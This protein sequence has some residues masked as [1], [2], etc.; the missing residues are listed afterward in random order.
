MRGKNTTEKLDDSQYNY[1]Q[2]YDLLHEIIA[3]NRNCD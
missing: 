2:A 3:D 1:F